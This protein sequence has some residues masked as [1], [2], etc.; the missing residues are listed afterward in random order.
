MKYLNTYKA[1]LLITLSI[2]ICQLSIATERGSDR[3]G[4]RDPQLDR[5]NEAHINAH[6][7]PAITEE[8]SRDLMITAPRNKRNDSYV[9]DERFRD[10][11]I[12]K[13][14]ESKSSAT[15]MSISEIANSIWDEASE[16]NERM[17]LIEDNMI[18]HTYIWYLM[19]DYK[20]SSNLQKQKQVKKIQ[21]LLTD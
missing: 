15:E 3:K 1:K 20:S 8:I 21:K 4:L 19:N 16:G 7:L 12:A 9:G 14:L 18:S 10:G 6:Y 2:V 11:V 17:L 13:S 5:D